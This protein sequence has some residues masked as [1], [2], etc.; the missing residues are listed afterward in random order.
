MQIH[1][2]R[3][4]AALEFLMTYGWA[5][6]VVLLVVGVLGYFGVFN[7]TILLPERCILGEGFRCKDLV[8]NAYTGNVLLNLENGLGKD[9]I[10]SEVKITGDE[11]SK[12]YCKIDESIFPLSTPHGSDTGLLIEGGKKKS[13]AIPCQN[14]AYN[15]RKQRSRITIV[16]KEPGSQKYEH[17]IQGEII[18]GMENNVWPTQEMCEIAV[19]DD[20]CGDLQIIFKPTGDFPGFACAC[21][22]EHNGLC[23]TECP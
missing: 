19:T 11:T 4:Q 16:Y 15:D 23:D 7:P 13:L 10:I 1:K 20:L 8:F 5:I 9:R 14:M 12:L 3:G 17:E 22:T 18:A 6:L 2:K 21:E